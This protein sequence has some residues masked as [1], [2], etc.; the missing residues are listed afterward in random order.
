MVKQYDIAL[1]QDTRLL[2]KIDIQKAIYLFADSWKE[3]KL[4]MIVD[5]WKK[6][7]ILLISPQQITINTSNT[8]MK[9]QQWRFK[10]LLN[11]FITLQW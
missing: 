7:G 5:C 11:K 1:N 9:I 10:I 6:T 4:K 8:E 2:Y 3:L